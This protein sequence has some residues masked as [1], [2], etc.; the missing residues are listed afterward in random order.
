MAEKGVQ[1]RVRFAPSPTGHFH[2]GGARTALF[3]WLFARQEDGKFILRIE[4]TDEERSKAEYEREIFDSLRWLGIVWDEGPDIGGPYGPYRQSERIATYRTYLEK[5]L[6]SGGA[7]YCYCTKEELD[8]QKEAMV[9]QGLPPKYSGHCRNLASPPSDRLPQVIRFKTPEASVTFKD[10]V[11]GAVSF[12]AGLFGDI[13]IAKDLDHPLYNFAVVIDDELMRITHVVRGEDHI[14]NAPKQILLDKA[15]G[16]REPMFA[17]LPLILSADRSKLSKRYA[18]TSLLKYRGE[19]YLPQAMVNFLV[20]LGWHPKGDKEVFSLEELVK[21]FSLARTQKAG[22]I[23]NEEKLAWLNKEHLKLLSAEEIEAL[24]APLVAEKGIAPASS[25]MI[26]EIVDVQRDR[27]KTLQDFFDLSDFFFVLPEYDAALLV[28]NDD[29]E[30]KSLEV[31]K[32]ADIA[33]Q[34]AQTTEREDLMRALTPLIE[35]HGKGS[36]LWPIRVALSGKNAS[37]DPFDIMRILGKAESHDR[38]M[39]ALKKLEGGQHLF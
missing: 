21:E 19:G 15:L 39:I 6:E 36:V 24:L 35:K 28:W 11:R 34:G 16:F 18:E 38:L 23:F 30:Q 13:V 37:P 25:E 20:L 27:M 3:N 14:S 12:D 10:M 29:S 17:H 7:Y 26:H 22:A 33:I 32:E 8:A 2:V 4:D 9:S 1:V 31:L 5:L